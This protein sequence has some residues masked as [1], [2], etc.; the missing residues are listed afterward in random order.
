[1]HTPLKWA[2]AAILLWPAALFADVESYFEANKSDHTLLRAFLQEMP[3]GADLHMHADGAVYSEDL[4]N[5]AAEPGLDLCWNPPTR[6]IRPCGT[7]T[8][9]AI[10]TQANGTLDCRSGPMVSMA[11][12]AT[13]DQCFNLIID[14]LSMRNFHPNSL[15][16]HRSGHDHFFATFDRFSAISGQRMARALAADMQNAASQNILYLEPMVTLMFPDLTGYDLPAELGNTEAAFAEFEAALLASP[17]AEEMTKALT[18]LEDWTQGAHDVMNCE[19]LQPEPG[20]DVALRVLGQSIRALPPRDVFA[21]IMLHFYVA[22]E[23]PEMV[24]VNFVAPEDGIVALRDYDLHMDI[25]AYFKRKFP[26]VGVALHAGEL[27]LGLV[28]PSELRFHIN[29]AFKRGLADRIGHGVDIGFETDAVALMEYIKANDR[30]VEINLSS[31]EA[32][33][34][35]W[36]DKHPFPT[37]LNQGVPVVLSTDDEG[38]SRIDL[39]SQYQLAVE[40]YDLDYPTLKTLSRR[41]IAASF[42]TGSSIWQD[43][44]MTAMVP[45]CDGQITAPA[46]IALGENSDK[47]ALE[48]ALEEKFQSFEAQYD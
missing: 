23:K 44:Q 25:F 13:Q 16:G 21:Q 36:G 33:L 12:A 28:K 45:A 2:L 37:Y 19:T 46:C 41:A 14:S 24:G 5:W 1:M 47:A 26:D 32:I 17:F 15:S 10:I 35:V 48:L 42:L 3:K 30:T 29:D 43:L 27:W 38:V 9:T 6:S 31:N 22:H 40:R 11:L 18:T 20:C 7:P 39:T 8:N 34:G 4:I